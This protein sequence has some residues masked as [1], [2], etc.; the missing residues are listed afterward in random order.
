MRTIDFC[1]PLP[2]YEHPCLVSYRHLSEACASPLAD[3]L[4]PVTR[5][6]VDLAVHD[7]ESA[8]VGCPGLTRDVFT[9]R[10]P[11][12]AEPLAPP[13]L[14]GFPAARFHAPHWSRFA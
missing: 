5:R 12:R 9:S 3:G 7:A 8:S 13:S 14:P 6:P 11:D 2:D 1:F 10:A 4:A